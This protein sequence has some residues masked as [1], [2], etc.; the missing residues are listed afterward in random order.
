MPKRV[1]DF[2]ERLEFQAPYELRLRLIALSYLLGL[3]SHYAATA[4][5]LLDQAM[6]SA[7]SKM[8][9][10]RRKDYNDILDNV[11]SAHPQPT[12]PPK[13]KPAMIP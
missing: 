7:V 9:P 13:K 3:G 6:T 5:N 1:R 10:E 2:P 11:R 8:S 12:P 4:R